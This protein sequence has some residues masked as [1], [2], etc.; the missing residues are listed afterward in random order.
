MSNLI[1]QSTNKKETFYELNKEKKC[2][3]Y[4]TENLLS[5]TIRRQKK[6]KAEVLKYFQKKQEKILYDNKITGILRKIF[7]LYYNFFQSYHSNKLNK[8]IVKEKK[9]GAV[10]N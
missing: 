9:A 8:A 10:Y 6:N 5:K 3:F 7:L 2:V 1:L 4:Y